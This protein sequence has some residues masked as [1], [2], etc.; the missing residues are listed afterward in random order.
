MRVAWKHAAPY[1]K[2]IASEDLLCDAG[3][4]NVAPCDNAEGWD[5]VGGG[6]VV[7]EGGAYVYL[8]LIRGDVR[9][10]PTEYCK[11]MTLQL[12]IYFN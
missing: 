6:R 3:S 5:A 12:K 11:A 10:K 2:Q 4:S 7:L 1:V 8:Q 9:Q